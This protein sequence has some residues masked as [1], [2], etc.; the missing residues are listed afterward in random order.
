M[1]L[2]LLRHAIAVEREHFCGEDRERPLTPD[3]IKKMRRIARGMKAM[4]LSFDLILTSP[5][6]R[7]KDTAALVA[8]R[9]NVRRHAKVTPAL[10]P[11]GDRRELM[12]QLAALP[13]HVTSVLLVGHEPYLSTLA[14]T[15]LN[16]PSGRL[17]LKKGG[18]CKLVLPSARPGRGA[19]L[20]W[21]LTPRQLALL[22]G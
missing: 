2:Y 18:L 4:K 15:L 9:F 19:E 22:A 3:G 16:G 12:R 14:M 17:R 11:L 7:A 5:Y 1:E 8:E 6:E 20:E 10:T 21:L 13:R